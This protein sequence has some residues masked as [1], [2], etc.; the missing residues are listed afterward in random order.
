M[1]TACISDCVG[2]ARCPIRR[3]NNYVSLQK[4]PDSEAEFVKST[5]NLGGKGR[6]H[7][8]YLH[9]SG[10]VVD[11]ASC[12]QLY[13]RSA[14][15]FSR[16]EGVQE[17]TKKCF[18]RVKEKVAIARTASTSRFQPRRR[19]TRTR[20]VM[21]RRVKDFSCGALRTIFQR[22]LSCTAT[23]DVVEHKI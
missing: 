20:F 16:E 23:V 8:N 18:G 2:D 7:N 4:W 5:G 10:V 21:V 15:T 11:S 6:L 3:T 13:L 1:T 22:L 12:R 17:R 19:K 9:R 14:Y